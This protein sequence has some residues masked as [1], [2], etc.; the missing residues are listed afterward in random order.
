MRSLDRYDYA[1]PIRCLYCDGLGLKWR[2]VGFDVCKFCD[3]TGESS[4]YE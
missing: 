1:D 4:E 3:G 2:K